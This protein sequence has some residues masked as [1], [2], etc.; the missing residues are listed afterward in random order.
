MGSLR[1]E[2]ACLEASLL[3]NWP[4][5]SVPAMPSHWLGADSGQHGL[6]RNTVA[7]SV[8]PK[9][10]VA[11]SHSRFCLEG[12]SER[13]TSVPTEWFLPHSRKASQCGSPCVSLPRK[14]PMVAYKASNSILESP[15]HC[16]SPSRQALMLY[17]S[18]VNNSEKNIFFLNPTS[19]K[20]LS[21]WSYFLSNKFFS[22]WFKNNEF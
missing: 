8:V 16:R 5:S 7:N 11:G 18:T 10:T 19:E 12:R 22:Y 21:P 1:A 6:S 3:E 2:A 9:G 4:W 17:V 15:W 13:H 14:L 20:N